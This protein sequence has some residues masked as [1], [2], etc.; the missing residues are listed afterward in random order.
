MEL[1][2]PKHITS[3]ATAGILVSVEVNV[4]SATKQDREISHEVTTAKKADDNA[5]RFVKN[6]LADNNLHKDLLNY[7]QTIYN[8]MKRR[9]FDWNKSQSYLPATAL[10]RF[11]EEY[12]QHE[13]T[14]GDKLETFL[15]EYNTIVSN[16]A[17]KQGQM[18]NRADYPTVDQVRNKFGMRLYRYEVPL[19]DFR[20]QISQDLADEMN[21]YYSKQAEDIVQNI[22]QDQKNRLID[23]MQSLTHCCGYD[24]YK[25]KDGEVKHKRRKIYEGTLEKAK[26][27]CS[28]YRGFNLTGDDELLQVIDELGAALR[29][30]DADSLRESDATR[31]A[32]KESVDEILQRF[33]PRQTGG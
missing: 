4:W 27:Y 11:M 17:F 23:V 12:N 9:T 21:D 20:C 29:G 32:V 24:E 7:R 13:Q 15:S 16:M 10:P 26:E 25:G 22:L 30:V 8:W 19:G 14:F 2:K 1:Q 31:S 18:F 28:D 33:A 5:G 3:L 6:L